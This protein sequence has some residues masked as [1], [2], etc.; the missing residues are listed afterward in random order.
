MFNALIPVLMSSSKIT[1]TA[2]PW[3]T[4]LAYGS[5]HILNDLVAT[6]QLGYTLL[7][8]KKVLQLD[9]IYSGMVVTSGQ[10]ADGLATIATGYFSDKDMNCGLCIRCVLQ[11]YS[12]QLTL[13][14]IWSVSTC[15]SE[16]SS[17]TDT[18]SA[19]LGI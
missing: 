4:R 5:G 19:R 13:Q 1:D 17:V 12:T 6:L 3:S 2:L 14:L 8:L 10:F 11:F 16:F 15:E 9:S 18:E 7:F